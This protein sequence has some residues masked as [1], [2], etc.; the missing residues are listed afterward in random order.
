MAV[1]SGSC[2]VELIHHINRLRP[3]GSAKVD[4]SQ[5][6]KNTSGNE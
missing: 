6:S 2:R 4:E 5:Q 1:P 3:G